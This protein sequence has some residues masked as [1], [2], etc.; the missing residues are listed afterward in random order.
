MK[1]WRSPL[2]LAPELALG[3]ITGALIFGLFVVGVHVLGLP[4]PPNGGEVLVAAVAALGAF[5]GTVLLKAPAASAA[6][7]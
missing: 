2:R 7:A 6:K 1:R 4:L 3:V 5:F